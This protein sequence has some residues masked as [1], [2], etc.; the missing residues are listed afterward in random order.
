MSWFSLQFDQGCCD[1]MTQSE[2]ITDNPW[3]P[4]IRALEEQARIAFLNGDVV[5]MGHDR[6][7]GPPAGDARRR[8]TNVWQL[9]NGRWRS[10]A[11]HAHVVAR[12]AG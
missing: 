11:R 12:A 1:R 5:V 7:T 4:E 9:E 2:A 8:Y 10:I 3:E 6:V